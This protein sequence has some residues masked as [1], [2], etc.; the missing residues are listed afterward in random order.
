MSLVFGMS[1]VATLMLILDLVRADAVLFPQTYAKLGTFLPIVSSARSSIA[2]PVLNRTCSSISSLFHGP[3]CLSTTTSML[4][5]A[6]TGSFS[7]LKVFAR[8]NSLQIIFGIA[9]ANAPTFV[10]DLLSSG[11]SLSVQSVSRV[12][13]FLSISEFVHMNMAS[14]AKSFGC[15]KVSSAILGF[16]HVRTFS[17]S[18]SLPYLGISITAHGNAC[19]RSLLLAPNRATPRSSSPSQSFVST[20]F[21]SPV[22]DWVA[23]RSTLPSRSFAHVNPLPVAFNH[24]RLRSSLLTQRVFRMEIAPATLDSVATGSILSSRGASYLRS[25]ILM[26]GHSLMGTFASPQAHT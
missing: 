11:S 7:S 19:L 9:C 5:Y 23:L 10:L 3:G 16:G 15:S 21:A 18:R 2:L 8:M 4:N 26:L 14:L 1:R 6:C 12:E 22:V 17:V 20:E 13:F 24:V 25:L